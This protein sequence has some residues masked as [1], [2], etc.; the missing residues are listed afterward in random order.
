VDGG[1][2]RVVLR[3]RLVRLSSVGIPDANPVRISRTCAA[4]VAPRRVD[5]PSRPPRSGRAV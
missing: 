4:F 3:S 1:E 2:L 5:L